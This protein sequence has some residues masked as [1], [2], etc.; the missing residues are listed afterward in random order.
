MQNAFFFVFVSIYV[1]QSDCV[2]VL[3]LSVEFKNSG[4]K[5]IKLADLEPCNFVCYI[6]LVVAYY[7]ILQIILP[8]Y[9][10]TLSAPSISLS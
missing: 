2:E 4:I 6:L 10:K 7:E 9:I 1:L 3:T 5:I 8:Y